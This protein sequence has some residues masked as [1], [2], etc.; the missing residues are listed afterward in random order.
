MAVQGHSNTGRLSAQTGSKS[1]SVSQS[2]VS[3]HQFGLRSR[4]PHGAHLLQSAEI[5]ASCFHCA[6]LLSRSFSNYIRSVNIH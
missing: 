5:T 4:F 6:K 2:V 3:N 1:Q